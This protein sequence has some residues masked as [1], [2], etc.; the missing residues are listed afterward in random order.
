MSD[1]DIEFII[2]SVCMVAV[3]GWK[4]LPQY[5]FNPE[6]GEWKHKTQQVIFYP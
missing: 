5:S 6:T 2:N 3:D 1:Q 4:Q